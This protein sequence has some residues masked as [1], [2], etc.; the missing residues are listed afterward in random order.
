VV[1]VRA[2]KYSNGKAKIYYIDLL[3]RARRDD[4]L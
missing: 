3:E 2:M 4:E 1:L